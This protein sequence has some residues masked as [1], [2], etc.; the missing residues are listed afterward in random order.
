MLAYSIGLTCHSHFKLLF[1]A[2]FRFYRSVKQTSYIQSNSNY[3]ELFPI[4]A[5][6]LVFK[7]VKKG[8]FCF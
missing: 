3:L 4:N 5:K 7:Y 2:S 1:L 8:V 6:V